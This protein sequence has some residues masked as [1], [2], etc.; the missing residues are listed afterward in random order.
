M[1]DQFTFEHP[2]AD[3]VMDALMAGEP[4]PR[5]PGVTGSGPRTRAAD[6][7]RDPDEIV[8]SVEETRYEP[9]PV[10]VMVNAAV[11]GALVVTCGIVLAMQGVQAVLA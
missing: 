3:A 11:I 6:R 7:F 2:S 1:N 5:T 4:V 9:S 8:I 10:E